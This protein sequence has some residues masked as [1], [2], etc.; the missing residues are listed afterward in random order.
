MGN[1]SKN[2]QTITK[3]YKLIKKKKN[4][5][6]LVVIEINFKNKIA[7]NELFFKEYKDIRTMK[8]HNY[9]QLNLCKCINSRD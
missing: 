8:S 9:T 4:V 2:A 6:E 7:K 5:C 3:S 1:L